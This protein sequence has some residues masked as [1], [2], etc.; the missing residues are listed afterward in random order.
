METNFLNVARIKRL[1]ELRS[2]L[3]S[4]CSFAKTISYN[5]ANQGFNISPDH[6]YQMVRGHRTVSEK[7]LDQMQKLV[8]EYEDMGVSA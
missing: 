5:L 8:V 4:R 2:K 1:K 3:P 7:V 6:I